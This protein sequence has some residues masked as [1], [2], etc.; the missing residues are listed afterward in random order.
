[1]AIPV[2]VGILWRENKILVAER[3][4]HKPYAGYWEFPGGKVEAHETELAAIQRELHEEL[5]IAVKH[6]KLW[7]Q[8]THVYPDKTVLLNLYFITDFSGEPYSREQQQ[9]RWVTWLELLDLR[10]LEGNKII[11]KEL[12]TLFSCDHFESSHSFPV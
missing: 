9:L 5:G 11:I 1:M 12:G 4:P 2:V 3:P 10:L 8:F 7:R 6:A